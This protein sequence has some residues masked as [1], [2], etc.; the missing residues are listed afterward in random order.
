MNTSNTTEL[1]IAILI[2]GVLIA[3]G[4]LLTIWTLNT[5]F[6]LGIDYN[7]FTWLAALLF[8]GT[9]AAKKASK[10]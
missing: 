3:V 7:F 4:P 9:F 2:V 5:L 10:D 1:I 6:D 8:T